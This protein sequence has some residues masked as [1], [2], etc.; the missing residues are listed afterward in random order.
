MN[1][2]V[3]GHFYLYMGKAEQIKGY[4]YLFN[5]DGNQLQ[6]ITTSSIL[7]VRVVLTLRRHLTNQ[8]AHDVFVF[9]DRVQLD[10]YFLGFV[11]I[12]RV[13]LWFHGC[14]ITKQNALYHCTW[15]SLCSAKIRLILVV[16]GCVHPHVWYLCFIY[17]VSAI[18]SSEFL[19]HNVIRGIFHGSFYSIVLCTSQVVV[20][21]YSYTF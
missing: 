21:C 13:C 19:L 2:G 10:N 18:Y 16:F 5:V 20:R 11:L 4:L 14:Y 1:P 9:C 15:C 12:V 17:F 7:L 6:M 8:D 3:R